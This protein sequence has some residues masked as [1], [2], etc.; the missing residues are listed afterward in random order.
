MRRFALWFTVGLSLL[1]GCVEV[2]PKSC[3]AGLPE[4]SPC[5]DGD[6]CT[7]VDICTDGLCLGIFK[8]C[9]VFDGECQFGQCDIT[10][11]DCTLQN[12]LDG[13][14][15]NDGDG[16]TEGETCQGGFCFGG[17][18]KV[19]PSSDPCVQGICDLETG[20]CLDKPQDDGTP[21]NDGDACTG[22]GNTDACLFNEANGTSTCVGVQ[23]FCALP[24]NFDA[25]CAVSECRAD[26]PIS[27]PCE[28][29]LEDDGTPCND[30]NAGTSGEVCVQGVCT[31]VAPAC[32][33]TNPEPND[34]ATLAATN[35]ILPS[36]GV[37]DDPTQPLPNP[38][39]CDADIDMYA[40]DLPLNGDG[41]AIEVRSST[42][43]CNFDSVAELRRGDGS[44]LGALITSNDNDG[45]GNCPRIAATNVNAGSL[46]ALV[47]GK[48]SDDTGP[49]SIDVDTIALS[50]GNVSTLETEPNNNTTTADRPDF[51]NGSYRGKL[52][53]ASDVDF[54]R[55]EVT[56]KSRLFAQV[57]N[58]AN[59]CAFDSKLEL[60][61]SA[62]T[63]IAT[64]S[65]GGP[66]GCPEIDLTFAPPGGF[67]DL[68]AGESLFLKVSSENNGVGSYQL[69]VIIEAVE[70][71][72]NDSSQLAEGPFITAAIEGQLLTNDADFYKVTLTAPASILAL[73][74]KKLGAACGTT[75]DTLIELRDISNTVIASSDDISTSNHC[76]RISET[77][78]PNAASPANAGGKDL[79]PG[80]YFLVVRGFQGALGDYRLD[81]A[82]V[83]ASETEPNSSPTTADAIPMITA[84]NKGA[85]EGRI[86]PFSVDLFFVDVPQGATLSAETSDGANGC[87]VDTLVQIRGPSGLATDSITIDDDTG[88]DNCSLATAT[89][90]PAG[91]YFIAVTPFVNASSAEGPYVLSVTVTP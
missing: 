20:E 28:I 48:T 41:I 49:Y 30:G 87:Q 22:E 64:A 38:N 24:A 51:F 69:D 5:D 4:G 17:E 40:I 8:D 72:S 56:S 47:K 75:L 18:P 77:I 81:I 1:A 80:T 50:N 45:E 27:D 13:S 9:S 12:A 35:S 32:N 76:S 58:A 26:A 19:C 6:L 16:C 59:G 54:A 10:T 53:S 89:N 91:R 33:N 15:C 79:A 14:N 70:H 57:N 78:A 90:L 3:D 44:A 73:T 62:N 2:N 43:G 46:F 60:V 68:N 71:G 52:S 84:Q 7:E 83:R 88:N 37:A 23:R 74:R 42:G 36:G 31:T 11:G 55:F 65:G 82:T 85:I 29:V 39:L 63:V 25:D 66:A 34:T 86:T 21:C 61:N 67:T